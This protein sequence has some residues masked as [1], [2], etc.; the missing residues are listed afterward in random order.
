MHE[1]TAGHTFLRHVLSLHLGLILGRV[2]T[3]V[4]RTIP[5]STPCDTP[6]VWPPSCI[7]GFDGA[8]S[9]APSSLI[10]LC[11]CLHQGRPLTSKDAASATAASLH[12]RVACHRASVFTKRRQE[13]TLINHGCFSS[14]GADYQEVCH[15][16]QARRTTLDTG[17]TF[18]V[19]ILPPASSWFRQ[20]STLMPSLLRSPRRCLLT[21]HPPITKSA[22]YATASLASRRGPI[23]LIVGLLQKSRLLTTLGAVQR[24]TL[25]ASLWRCLG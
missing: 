2:A 17:A 1:E 18:Q 11:R 20:V 13:H 23:R 10:L 3:P 24:S 21:G 9:L 5:R 16:S 7:V 19:C 22:A 12:V 4:K 25:A 15:A 6:L 14:L 8:L